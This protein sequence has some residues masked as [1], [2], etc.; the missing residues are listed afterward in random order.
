MNTDRFILSVCFCVHPWFRNSVTVSFVSE[1]WAS[2]SHGGTLRRC[3][4][5]ARAR[6]RSAESHLDAQRMLATCRVVANAIW[7]G[8]RV[9]KARRLLAARPAQPEQ[10]A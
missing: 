7:G 3:R 5:R 4:F 1:Y 6:L 2:S 9:G 10:R 8:N